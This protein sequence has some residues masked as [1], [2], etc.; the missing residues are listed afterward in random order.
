MRPT[1]Y[2][3]VTDS[4]DPIRPAYHFVLPAERLTLNHRSVASTISRKVA[5]GA[6]HELNREMRGNALHQL[7]R[8][9][10]LQMIR[11]RPDTLETLQDLTNPQNAT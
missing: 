3:V 11:R 7:V 8:Y 1:R 2:H 6:A 5:H 10:T 9:Q 4:A